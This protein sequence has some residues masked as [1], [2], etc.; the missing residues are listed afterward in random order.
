MG[1]VA[2]LATALTL[3]APPAPPEH[4]FAVLADNQLVE[5]AVPSGRVVA[6]RR[7]GAKPQGYVTAG[8]L[9]A[10]TPDHRVF[11]L[12][13]TG[14]GRDWVAVVDSRTSRLRARYELEPGVRYRGIAPAGDLLYAYGGRYG[15]EVDTTNHWR[16]ES[17][18]VT[19]LDAGSGVI[20]TSLTV[21]PTDGHMWWIYWG[22]AR[23]DGT[24][25]ALAYHGG[26][27]AEATQLCTSGAD[28]IDADGATLHRCQ[29]QASR[30]FLG[31]LQDAHGM[32]EPYGAGWIATTGGE[33][34]VQ[35]GA[36]GDVLRRLHTG[37]RK[38]HVMS[39]AFNDDRSRLYALSSC[40]YSTEGLRRVSLSGGRPTL[41]GRRI[42]GDG[43]VVGRTAF[44]VRRGSAIDLRDVRTAKL[45]EV[46][47][48]GADV[49]DL[50]VAP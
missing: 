6:R 42:C 12:V 26:C 17:A 34:L 3:S 16:E 46:R 1:V 43:L 13:Q 28:W 50:A 36:K 41:V 21:R 27:F 4:G 19:Q 48:L 39:F 18:V 29:A 5:L 38:D 32:I 45:L 31:C 25:V 8:R 20:R 40:S 23:G 35:Y 9:L 22:S 49:L 30:S 14:T 24:R 11:V 15:R 37:I 33:S 7:L 10:A 2:L 44:L 47:G